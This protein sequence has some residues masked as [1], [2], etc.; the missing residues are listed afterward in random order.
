MCSSAALGILGWK[1]GK[2]HL[3]AFADVSQGMWPDRAPPSSTA[4]SQGRK[5][6]GALISIF[7]IAAEYSRIRYSKLERAMGVGEIEAL[8]AR[9][10]RSV[11][12]SFIRAEAALTWR[13]ILVATAMLICMLAVATVVT[14]VT[15]PSETRSRQS[16][17]MATGQEPKRLVL[18]LDG[19]W[20]TVDSNT[21]VWRMR[22]LCAPR[23][24]DG[25][26]QL[27]YYSIGVNGFLGGVFGQG[28]D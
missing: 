17:S 8:G 27:I 7:A 18:F 13:R 14:F 28:I 16:A 5:C 25:K 21:N 6:V 3:V 11:R 23:G 10:L 20:N 26:P 24:D 9:L 15:R 4:P 1:P 2:V 12:R 22:A 19:T